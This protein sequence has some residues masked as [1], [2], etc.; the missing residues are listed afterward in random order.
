METKHKPFS[1]RQYH[2]DPH[3]CSNWCQICGL[4]YCWHYKETK[5]EN[6]KHDYR[7][8]NHKFQPAEC[9]D[10]TVCP[11]CASDYHHPNK[12]EIEENGN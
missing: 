7:A 4:Y 8:L 3:H 12:Q 5:N 6:Y 10:E 1:N 2:E 9:G 11:F